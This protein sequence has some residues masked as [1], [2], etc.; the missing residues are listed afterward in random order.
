[1]T[2]LLELQQSVEGAQQEHVAPSMHLVANRISVSPIAE[3]N[4]DIPSVSQQ[5]NLQNH[6]LAHHLENQH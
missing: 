6:E 4:S 1:V 5:A 3:R 2:Y